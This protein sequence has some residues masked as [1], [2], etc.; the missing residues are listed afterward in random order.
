MPYIHSVCCALPPHHYDQDALIQRFLTHWSTRMVNPARL[1]ALHRHV[2]VGGRHLA[3]P[4]EAYEHLDGLH[5]RNEAWLEV[6][7]DL[8]EQAV[9][10]VLHQAQFPAHDIRLLTSSTVTGIAVPSLEARLMNRL[11][12]ARDTK[13]V[14]L[15]GLGY[16]AGVA[17]INRVA[18]YLQGH[19]QDAAIFFS[20]ELC[21]PTLQK[22][23]LSIPNLIA[24]GLFGDGG[25]A[26]LLLGDDHPRVAEAPLEL[27]AWHS[28]FFPQTDSAFEIPI[29]S[30]G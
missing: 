10:G 3:L 9:S 17:G 24:S 13:R 12:F 14:P 4:L 30:S 21:S 15:F 16:L 28:A 19:P 22:D 8:A 29:L 27:V 7:L 18:D 1:A 26:V 11:P 25:A 2:L 23:D 6:A 20:V 5:A